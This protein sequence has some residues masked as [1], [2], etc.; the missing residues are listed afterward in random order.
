[1]RLSDAT[2][3]TTTRRR[4]GVGTSGLV[5]LAPSVL[6]AWVFMTGLVLAGEPARTTEML[7]K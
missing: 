2:C 3:R 6:A 5:G 7:L 4:R 1:M